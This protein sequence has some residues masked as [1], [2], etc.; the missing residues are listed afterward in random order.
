VN[1]PLGVAGVLV[2]RRVLPFRPPRGRGEFDVPGALTFGI[3]L[4]A[5]CLGL[6]FG[7][8]WGWTSARSL[9]V[10]VVAAVALVAAVA[11]ELRRRDP[12]VD[13]RM[14]AS[15]VLGSAL[16]SFLLSI[17][18]CS[19][20]ASCCPSTSRSCAASTRSAPACC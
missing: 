14:L 18:A 7:R 9:V 12:L 20:W 11:V 10:L 8:E 19:R 13:V 16:L 2:A 17:L 6:S 15:R 3:G 5:L 4:A 1:L